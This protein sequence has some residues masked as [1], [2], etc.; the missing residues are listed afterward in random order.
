MNRQTLLIV[1][2]GFFSAVFV[3]IIVQLALGSQKAEVVVELEKPAQTIKILV[4]STNIDKGDTLKAHHMKWQEWPKEALFTG[5]I[6]QTDDMSLEDALSGKIR[7]D[8]KKGEALMETAVLQ[9]KTDNFL[10]AS[11]GEGKRAVA[12]KVDAA[13]SVAGFVGPGDHVDIIM[14]YDLRLPSDEDIRAA[15]N[16]VI[17]KKAVQTIL[18][19]VKV[20][21][22]D[23]DMQKQDKAKVSRTITIEVDLRQAEKLALSM[24]MGKLSLSLRKFGDNT[25]QETSPDLQP[26]ITDLR[27]SSVMQEVLNTSYEAKK[28]PNEN[29]T[30]SKQRIMR[31]YNGVSSSDVTLN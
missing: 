29:K 6:E 23:Q 12:I 27:L 31:I 21:A 2:G 7:R 24:T 3:A 25:I 26:P 14:T 18:Q 19:N 9:D 1:S 8:I 28:N 15:A 17:N 13:S 20:I 4:A 10:S 11:L 5:A 22:T 16:E 30:R